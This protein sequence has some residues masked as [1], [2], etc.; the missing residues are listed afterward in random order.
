MVD[1]MSMYALVAAI[2]LAA[3]AHVMAE[4]TP[5]AGRTGSPLP[6]PARARHVGS[7]CLRGGFEAVMPLKP[8][9][10]GVPNA[11]SGQNIGG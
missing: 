10:L 2:F 6:A 5:D 1:K 9:N 11:W 3:A 8:A 4:A 7:L